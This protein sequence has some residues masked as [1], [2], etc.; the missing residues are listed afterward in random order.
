M[1][2]A[3]GNGDSILNSTRSRASEANRGKRPSVRRWNCEA[4]RP[5]PS[6]QVASQSLE[7]RL[8]PAPG[9]RY[10]V[11]SQP[12]PIQQTAAAHSGAGSEI[13][14][15]PAPA[16]QLAT[17][18]LELGLGIAGPC[19]LPVQ[20]AAGRS[21]GRLG[22]SIGPAQR[23]PDRGFAGWTG[24]EV[25]TIRRWQAFGRWPSRRQ[26]AR[27]LRRGLTQRHRSHLRRECA[28]EPSGE[29]GAAGWL[30]HAAAARI[31][32]GLRRRRRTE[33]MR[34]L[35]AADFWQ[36]APRDLKLLAIAIPIL[37]G[38]ALRPSLPKVRVTAPA[39]S[40]G[41][42]KNLGDGFRAQFVNV[43]NSV[44]Q[45][46]AV[47]LNEDFRSGLDDWQT[48]GDLSTGWSFDDNGF[49][50][51]G[52]LALYR[53]SLGLRDY[54][55]EFLGMVDKKALSW[56]VRAKDF[57]NYY[58]VKLVVTKAG[59]LPTMGITRYA[60]IDGKAQPA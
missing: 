27:R 25:D 20:S 60:V 13:S 49:V 53:P 7:L 37:L 22:R 59:P 52:T 35:I 3:A 48:R 43:R 32:G 2:L 31:P 10:D 23:T 9:C 39:T 12:G 4:K 45:R 47:A 40:G 51:P 24:H 55:M 17:Q 30:G 56:V 26:R 58:V 18:S 46:A 38:L 11:Q 50:K 36:H 19:E 41:I 44:A 5:A 42:S 1:Q 34:G 29:V 21:A 28:D 16:K 33:S 6:L 14:I 8:R 15:V 57:D 54:E